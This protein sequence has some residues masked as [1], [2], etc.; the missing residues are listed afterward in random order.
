MITAR[1]GGQ[2]IR[3]FAGPGDKARSNKRKVSRRHTA[4]VI[5]LA[6]TVANFSFDR[7]T[8]VS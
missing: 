4:L 7:R 2:F 3:Q 1:R 8:N 6:K 5:D